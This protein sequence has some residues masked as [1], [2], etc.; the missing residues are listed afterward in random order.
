MYEFFSVLYYAFIATSSE[1]KSPIFFEF[2]DYYNRFE[3]VY[4]FLFLGLLLF[5]HGF[6]MP[7]VLLLWGKYGEP[8][9]IFFCESRFEI[10]LYLT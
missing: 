9:G 2:K 5:S 1:Y 4:P 6:P 10:F 3:L 8:D 7:L